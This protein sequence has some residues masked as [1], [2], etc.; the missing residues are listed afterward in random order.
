MEILVECWASR[1]KIDQF[2]NGH[3]VSDR[4]AKVSGL[5]PAFFLF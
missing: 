2:L 4:T 5:N 3:V 1:V